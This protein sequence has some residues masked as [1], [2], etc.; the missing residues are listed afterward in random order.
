MDE[1]EFGGC[2][3][4]VQPDE[5]FDLGPEEGVFMFGPIPANAIAANVKS[6]HVQ[7]TARCHCGGNLVPHKRKPLVW[8]CDRSHWWNRRRGHAYLIGRMQVLPDP[9]GEA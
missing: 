3:K 8:I 6:I 2:V 4:Q 1:N 7:L 5:P 9:E